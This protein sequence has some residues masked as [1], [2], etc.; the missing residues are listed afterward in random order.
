MS[1]FL[2][3]GGDCIHS[4]CGVQQGDHLG[5]LG[6]ALTLHPIVECIKDEVPD[7]AL[8][9]WYFNDGTLVGFP[10][11]LALA[12]SIIKKFGPLVGLHLMRGKSIHP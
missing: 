5:P 3:L 2:H 8:N 6:F 9:A 4:C 1:T 11:D 7:L 10:E 12:L